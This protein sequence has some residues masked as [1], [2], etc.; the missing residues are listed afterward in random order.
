M[1]I[2]GF[3]VRKRLKILFV[4][5]LRSLPN[6]YLFYYLQLMLWVVC[7]S[8]SSS[9]ENRNGFIQPLDFQS[10]FNNKESGKLLKLLVPST[11][12]LL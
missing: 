2:L 4:M 9:D 12:R 3:L 10:L 8:V 5:H 7:A 6:I 11:A 1:H